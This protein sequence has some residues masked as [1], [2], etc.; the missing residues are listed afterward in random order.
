MT[1]TTLT[2]S[3]IRTAARQGKIDRAEHPVVLS[4][5]ALQPNRTIGTC[6]RCGKPVSEGLGMYHYSKI[7]YK[8]II[9][10]KDCLK[11]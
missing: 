4:N 7:E 8:K 1:T 9:E 3:Q 5:I 10:H 2:K 11:G 6:R